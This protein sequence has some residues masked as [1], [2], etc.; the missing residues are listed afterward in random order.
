MASNERLEFLGDAVLGMVV[1]DHIYTAYPQLAEGALAKV[2]ATVVSAPTLAGIAEGLGLG[3]TL[4]LGKGEEV[5]G[6]RH[7]PSILAD[8]LEA[9]IGAL[10]LD[11]G[12]DTAAATVRH[13]FADA[14]D[15]AAAGPGT[16]DF[17][18]RLQELAAR[19]FGE[20]PSYELSE[21]GPDHDKRFCARVHLGG[22]A[23]GEGEGRSKKEA[24]QAAA[25]AAFARLGGD[26]P[27]LVGDDER[28]DRP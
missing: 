10:Y 1:T 4:L 26:R 18:T 28:G 17:K 23:L 27:G 19:H 25:T 9:V 16:Q 5:S 2:R 24:E 6:G 22:E 8:A 21:S 20:L 12:I 13:L 14:V 15:S 3:D 7:K 11:G